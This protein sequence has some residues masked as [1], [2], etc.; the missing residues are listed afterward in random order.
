M[1][2]HSQ[3]QIARLVYLD[4]EKLNRFGD[5]L[6]YRLVEANHVVRTGYVRLASI[7]PQPKDTRP[8]SAV[9][10]DELIDVEAAS[11]PEKSMRLCGCLRGVTQLTGTAQ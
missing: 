1:T 7:A 4:A 6:I 9:L 10:G 5:R 8:Q 11:S 2:K 3:Q